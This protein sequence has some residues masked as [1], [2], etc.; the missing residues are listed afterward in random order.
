[1]SSIVILD[2]VLHE[3]SFAD[4]QSDL[5]SKLDGSTIEEWCLLDTKHKFRDICLSLIKLIW[6][7]F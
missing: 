7:L 4:I 6:N 5:I 3:D 1:M 2:N